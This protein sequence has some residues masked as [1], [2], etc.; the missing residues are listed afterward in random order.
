MMA[1]LRALR[2]KS[3][4]GE[5]VMEGRERLDFLLLT[6]IFGIAVEWSVV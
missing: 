1:M 6:I 3:R 2:G 5:P 4:S